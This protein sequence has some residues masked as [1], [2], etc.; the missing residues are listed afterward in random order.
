MPLKYRDFN[1]GTSI[2]C[3]TIKRTLSAPPLSPRLLK[4]SFSPMIRI[5]SVHLVLASLALADDVL[6]ADFESDNFGDLKVERSAFGKRPATGKVGGQQDVTGFLGK[7]LAHSFHPNDD[8]TGT[9]TSPG[10]T[11]N[12]KWLT[13]YIGGGGW[14]G[15]TCLNLIIDGE[16]VLTAAGA[17]IA[18]GGN[19]KL[20]PMA[21][22]QAPYEGKEA[23]L[24]AVDKR[25]G[26]WGHLNL[27]HLVLTDDRGN[28]PLPP[29]PTAEL[30]RKVT[31]P[32]STSARVLVG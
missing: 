32:N 5:I 21:W 19:E 10:F 4:T 20:S 17:N 2:H 25:K 6:L 7:G 15:E 12:R 26:G 11:I 23:V 22:A 28:I 18:S 3:L 30:T 8:S 31:V 13:F 29:Q 1:L 14:G 27:D 16:I 9:L 24:Q